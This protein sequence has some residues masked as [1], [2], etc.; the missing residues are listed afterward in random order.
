MPVL[1]FCLLSAAVAAPEDVAQITAGVDVI[2]SAGGVPN[3]VV[4]FG[5]QAFV[6][7]TGRAGRHRSPAFVAARYGQGR[8]VAGGHESYFGEAGAKDPDNELLL[9][10]I[11]HW[12]GGKRA[13][14]RVVDYRSGVADLPFIHVWNT[15]TRADDESLPALLAES[16]VAV[17]SG[18]SLTGRPALIE[19]LASFVER[20]GGLLI[21]CVAWGWQQLNPQGSILDDLGANLLCTRM[22]FAWPDSTLGGNADGGWRPDG[23]GLEL[24][25]AGNALAALA[26]ADQTPLEGDRLGQVTRTLS[27]VVRAIQP[28]HPFVA[29]LQQ[30]CGEAGEVVPSEQTPIGLDNPRA[31]VRMILDAALT[32]PVDQVTAHPA[33]AHFPGAVPAE[34]E[35]VTRELSFDT[36]VPAWH[37]TALYAAPGEVLTV[38]LPEAAAGAGL[39]LRIGCHSDRLW[40]L[41]QWKRVPDITQQTPLRE[42]TTRIASPFGGLIYLVVPNNSQL[43]AVSVRIAGAVEAPLFISGR[44]TAE[45]WRAV[46]ER[47]APWGEFGSDKVIFSVPTRVLRTLDDPQELCD[48][49]NSVMD[50]C[51]DLAQ[52]PRERGRPERYV[53]DVQ[54]SAGYM[55]SGYPIM[56][57]MDQP[58]IMTDRDRLYREGSWGM[59]HEMGHNHQSGH[60]T[61]GGTG[62]VTCNLFTLYA[63]ET[64][65][66]PEAKPHPATTREEQESRYA[67]YVAG[68][69]KFSDWQA[70][71]F[72][73]L[74]LYI[75]LR[76]EFG[77]EPFQNVF[78]A[79]RD[80]PRDELP[81][82]DDEKR[83]QWLV[84][85]SRE[86]GRNLGP[87]FQAWGVPTSEAARQSIADLPG[88]MPEGME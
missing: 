8:V 50:A 5:E 80:A 19:A 28:E 56:T 31:R 71:P 54:I 4:V 66:D 20:G 68:G 77:W 70:D 33:A 58:E 40:D 38:T 17:V 45:E 30:V 24:S 51:A 52:I 62:E 22:G 53:P 76:Q 10:N 32:P 44:T 79:Y 16:D 74:I 60:W 21:N 34:A 9:Q 11:V 13:G 49:W 7:M 78:R 43:G 36:R 29:A 26:A 61:F 75:Q 37:S 73:A 69:R 83:D 39:A 41:D 2:T 23:E 6:V 12:L 67:K 88:W 72:L 42:A 84:R 15:L 35:R 86:V 63:L 25:H 18:N 81:R 48:F 27:D 3:N 46:R 82:N 14:L 64:C 59:F 87:F 55:H 1:L 65:C 47:P 85:F 57:W